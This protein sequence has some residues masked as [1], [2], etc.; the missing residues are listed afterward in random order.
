MRRRAQIALLY[1]GLTA[2]WFVFWLG[3]LRLAAIIGSAL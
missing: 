3:V 2:L 1:L